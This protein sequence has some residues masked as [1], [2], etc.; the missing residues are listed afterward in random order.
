MAQELIDRIPPHNIEAEQSL[1]GALLLDKEA[2]EKIADSVTSDDFYKDAHGTIFEVVLE[3]YNKHEPIDLLTLGNRLEER[4]ALERVGGRSYLI[5][6][7]NIVPTSANIGQ[8]AAIIQKKASL[9]RLQIAATEISQLTFQTDEDIET[10]L[11]KA[12]Q[13]IYGVS[14]KFVKKIF[15]PLSQVLTEAYERIEMIHRDGGGLKGIPTGFTGLDNLLAGLQRSD[16]VIL[17]ARP[18]VG[19]TSLVLD[20]AR[21][22][23]TATG[24]SVALFSLEMS[25][26]QLV[27]R[28]ICSQA[29][30]DLW[31]MRTGK[32]SDSGEMND[33]VKLGHAMDTL[34]KANIYIDDTA[35]AGIIEIRTKARRLKS[36]HGLDLIIIDYLQLMEGRGNKE[37]RVQ[38]VAEITRGLKAI[39]RELDV[40]VVAL[41]Q[42]ARAVELNKP[43]IPRLAHLRESGS[44]EQDAD[45]VLFIYRK[46]ADP[47]Y[48]FEDLTDAEKSSAEV[49]IAKHR[50][51]PTGMV[52]LFFDATKASYRNIDTHHSVPEGAS[53]F[54]IFDA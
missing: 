30:V 2:M 14:Q 32:L 43:A 46:A 8:Y 5:G 50:N 9:R 52:E 18:A 53:S 3:L 49:H 31:K 54:N 27:D 35:S 28:M 47:N 42:L 21:N 48:R 20:M 39:A 45:V 38:E 36:E 7:S 34:S 1:L 11:D 37:G 6:L 16:L 33:F 24:M 17:A 40:P 25:K 41:S 12:E 51:G 15:T 44:I 26:E 13:K 23:A 19:K 10:L 22:A 4:A 29:N